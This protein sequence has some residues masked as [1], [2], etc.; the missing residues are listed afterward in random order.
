MV[1]F[2]IEVYT[3]AKQKF[4]RWNNRWAA[5]LGPDGNTKVREE[6]KQKTPQELLLM[7]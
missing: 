3:Y 2:S 1:F 7:D 5:K 4:R 6:I